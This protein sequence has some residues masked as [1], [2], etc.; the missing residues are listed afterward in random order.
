MA[1]FPFTFTEAVQSTAMPRLP[2]YLSYGDQSLLVA[3]L[4]DTGSSVSVLPYDVGLTLGVIWE[5]QT[6]PLRLAGS[7]G[8]QEARAIVLEA[9]FPRIPELN[10]SLPLA[11]A[12]SRDE[13]APLLLGQTN[14]F[15]HFDVCMYR[16]KGYFEA[17]PT[18]G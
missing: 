17:S 13:N 18:T 11:F 5:E 6:L 8:K 16:S 2:F 1:R 10:A 3:E 14:F 15:E 4:V 12:W 9:T 7:L